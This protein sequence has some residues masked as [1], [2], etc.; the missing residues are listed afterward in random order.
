MT[1]INKS[2]ESKH[3]YFCLVGY[4]HAGYSSGG[5]NSSAQ[6]RPKGQT[7][8]NRPFAPERQKVINE[9]ID[10]L[11]AADFIRKA[12]YPDWL[13]TIVM[14]KKV[15]RKWR[16]YIDYTNLNKTCPKNNFFLSKIDQ[17]VDAISDHRLLS[18][19]DAFIEHN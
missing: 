19:M 16:I 13:A 4:R 3:R 6:H 1:T 11:L 17:L 15:N 10:K 8:E 7:G 12:T 18:F 14:V 2:T 5:S 9:E